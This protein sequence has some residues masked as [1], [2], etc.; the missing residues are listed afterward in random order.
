MHTTSSPKSFAV[1]RPDHS[2]P[3]APRGSRGRLARRGWVGVLGDAAAQRLHQI[4]HP[5]GAANVGLRSGT[6]PACLALRCASSVDSVIA[7][8]N[9]MAVRS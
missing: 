6:A 7:A 2:G 4:D 1:A 5:M 3:F 8:L 9:D